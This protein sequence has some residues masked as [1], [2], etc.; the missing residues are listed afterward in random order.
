MLSIIDDVIMHSDMTITTE[1]L[2]LI[3][4]NAVVVLG[5]RTTIDYI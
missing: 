3:L 1:M 5:V 4:P 2:I